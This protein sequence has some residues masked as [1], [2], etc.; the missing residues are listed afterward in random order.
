MIARLLPVLAL[1]LLS[2]CAVAQQESQYTSFM[3]N[4]QYYN[5]ATAGARGVAS[6][7]GLYRNQWVGFDDAPTSQMLTFGTPVL[8]DALGFG[9]TLNHATK[10]IQDN[11]YASMAYNYRLKLSDE[12]S[13]RIGLQGSVQRWG[14]DFTDP[15]V[16]VRTGNDES[17]DLGNNFSTWEGNV[18]LGAYLQLGDY[19][20]VGL[21]SPHIYRSQIS[22]DDSKRADGATVSPHVYFM[23]DALIPLTETLDFKPA[24]LF[25]Y[26]NG[27]PLDFETNLG[28]VYAQRIMGGVGY[29][30][31]GDG[32][33]DAL[34]LLAFFQLNNQLGFGAAYDIGVS[35]ISS[36]TSGSIEALARFDFGSNRDDLVNPRFF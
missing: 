27:A 28:L 6:L 17:I 3:Y 15:S 18:G 13:L 8:G 26:V 34:S 16:V 22:A 23:A 7:Q 20:N 25:K 2:L 12:H 29:R 33:G 36:N 30:A 11:L 35:D 14:I 31:G 4:Q 32:S 5:P 24:M 9:L 19:L 21:S 1:S 10:G